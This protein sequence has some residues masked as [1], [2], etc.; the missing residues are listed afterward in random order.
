M[1]ECLPH[2]LAL[3]RP[4]SHKATR[5]FES[6]SGVWQA[7][8]LPP[9]GRHPS[10]RSPKE[11]RQLGYACARSQWAC[12]LGRQCVGLGLRIIQNGD[13]KRDRPHTHAAWG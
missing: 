5:L 9:V 11:R 12:N 10:T 13:D 8:E 3:G 1:A 4:P 6:N 7:P 2:N